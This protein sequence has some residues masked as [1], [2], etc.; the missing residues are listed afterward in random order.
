MRSL[1][2]VLVVLAYASPAHSQ[3]VIPTKGKE[4]WVGF[5][6]MANFQVSSKRC[7]LFITSEVSTSGTVSIPQTGWTQNFTVIA[8]QTTTL[9]LPLA[10]V[11]HTTSEAVDNR[12]V[13]VVS[14][15]TISVFSIAFQEYTSDATVIYPKQ[16]LGTEYRTCSYPGLSVSSDPKVNSELLIVAT[17]DGTQVA[18]TPSCA[19]FGGRPAGVPFNVNLNAGQS[20]QVLAANFSLDLTGT[21]I[22]ATDSSG[23]CRP[24]AV[25]SGSTCVNIPA[26]C[27]ACDVLYEQSIPVAYWGKTYFA[28]PFSFASN[29]TL[30]VLADQNNTSFTI[31]GGPPTILNAGQF[32][33][34]N[35]ITGTQCIT[36][37]QP[38]CVAQYMQGINCAGAGDPAMMFL[39]AQDQ[40]ID[41][42]TFST[43]TS[44]VINQ[45]NVNVIM[46]TSHTGQLKLNG[47]SV[48]SSSFSPLSF[49]S[50]MSYAQLSLSQGSHTL[51]ADS[52]FT[53][54]AYGTGSAES[55]A[56]SVGSFSKAP[57]ILVDSF[58]CTSDTIQLG[59]SATLF[60]SWWST[61]TNPLDTFAV[62]PVLTLTAPIVPDIYI[63]HGDEFISGCT[64]EYYYE[65]EV[66]DPPTL[67]VSAS[68]ITVCQNQL[69]QLS[70]TP[71]PASSNY[72]YSWTPAADLNNPGSA[73]P[74]AT[75]SVSKWYYVTV[76]S[77]NGCAPSV[78]DSVYLDVLP[79]PLP[80]ASGG[81]NQSICLGG[82]A[83][84]SASGGYSYLWSPGGSTAS[85][86]SVSPPSTSNYIVFV[87]DTNGCGNSDTVTVSVYPVPNTSAGA[88][89]T[90]CMG[91]TALLNAS[92]G[93]SY[94]W[95][96]N[97]STNANISVT[98][99]STTTYSV[100]INDSYGCTFS[101]SVT[102]NVNPLPVANAGPDQATCNVNPVTLT[103]S[104]GVTYLWTPGN[105][106]AS[107]IQV[108]PAVSTN[109]IVKVT[110]ANG[111][112]D[113]DSVYV[114][115]HPFVSGTMTS[116]SVCVNDPVSLLASGGVSYLWSP[117]GS[118]DSS[119]TV[120][121]QT[122]T[123]FFVQVTTQ[124]GCFIYD[125]I[126]V[127]VNPLP[128]ANAGTD[129]VICMGEVATLIASGGVSYQWLS[130][131]IPGAAFVVSPTLSQQY[132]VR[133]TDA[134]G[135]LNEDSV[136]VSVNQLPVANA[137]ADVYI[138]PGYSTTLTASGG[139]SYQWNPG[140]STGA[141]ILVAPAISTTYIVEVTSI[142]GCTNNDTVMV[143]LNEVPV[144]QF[145]PPSQVCA[146]HPTTFVNNSSISTGTIL[147]NQWSFGDGNISGDI[148]G[149]NTYIGPGTY[150]VRLIATASNGCIDSTNYDVTVNE[151]P[152]VEFETQNICALQP[153]LFTDLSTIGT[154]VISNWFW[155]FGDGGFDSTKH[156]H[157]SYRH[158]GSYD[159][160]LTAWSDSGCSSIT[161]KIKDITVFPLPEASFVCQPEL[162]SILD[163]AVS[164]LN[165]SKG[166][167]DYQWDFGDGKGV[168]NLRHPFYTYTDTGSF[169][170]QLILM[171]SYNCYD[172]SYGRL[173]VEPFFSVYFPNAFTPNGDQLND[174]FTPNGEG[175][176]NL[177]LQIFN[178]WGVEIF[179]ASG[180]PVSWDGISKNGEKEGLEGVYVYI[181]KVTDYMGIEHE[182]KGSVTLVR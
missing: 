181:A 94:Q 160:T 125:T 37:N 167:L 96:N 82:T 164:F 20:Y 128:P 38:V 79:L 154:G 56:Y 52:G 91:S 139:L 120:S 10:S 131:S 150:P 22:A 35:N 146:N 21:V 77:P 144:V 51:Q 7:E 30:R 147:L 127:N 142:D 34:I 48:P 134:N 18:I 43:V 88:D 104:G 49:C 2:T 39:N 98:P 133:V 57:P 26:G 89:Q 180:F 145:A 64:K 151:I 23:S 161:K 62:G 14:Q 74:I 40:K 177:E 16:S 90:I 162:V 25:F 54:Y 166:G 32:T 138:C 68:A 179:N 158:P 165:T 71:F 36:S 75:A 116:Q 106:T 159:V 81:A 105:N 109:Y 28:V 108:S 58:V 9:A 4:F 61:N 124:V 11:E 50:T 148:I 5:P 33:E 47:V 118:T 12:G 149:V 1:L 163:P 95:L 176:R 69:V 3:G 168:S 136:L 129:T 182:F 112:D 113:Y 156:P 65:V 67:S 132:I 111:C 73:N 171:N 70:A 93:I 76:S 15:D 19:T 170:V 121:L 103:A 175:I 31:D 99:L 41:Q 153:T 6:Y 130:N 141:A 157:H 45:H 102:V 55:Y 140:A 72:V 66:P 172:T 24:F 29:Y 169:N 143:Y 135:C 84:L 100:I 114:T 101:N 137:G 173:Y 122:T 60:G 78:Q 13:K 115:V 97:G 119:I 44:S 174:Q 87:T 80:T 17:E 152:V 155:E 110:D 59:G 107:S 86:I 85:S 42:V 8:N 46:N 92:G 83:T 178:R 27:A 53:A 63:Q 123:D 126:H 117:G